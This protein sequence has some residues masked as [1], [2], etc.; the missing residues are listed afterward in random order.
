MIRQVTS[1]GR[2]PHIHVV[3]LAEMITT[4]AVLDAEKDMP[5]EEVIDASKTFAGADGLRQPSPPNGGD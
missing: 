4:S 3:V 5:M 2:G 1:W